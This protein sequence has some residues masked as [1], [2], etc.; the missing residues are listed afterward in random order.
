MRAA[1]PPPGAPAPSAR[2]AP[3]AN[4][5]VSGGMFQT[6]AWT[7]GWSD[8]ASGSSTIRARQPVPSGTAPQ[9]K[10]GETPSPS[11]VNRG[12]SIAPSA[13]AGLERS[14]IPK[15]PPSSGWAMQSLSAPARTLRHAWPSQWGT[16]S[17]I[18]GLLRVPDEPPCRTKAPATA[19]YKAWVEPPIGPAR[20]L[21]RSAE[22][23]SH[24]RLEHIHVDVLHRL[25]LDAI[26]GDFRLA[27]VASI[28]LGQVILV[29]DSKDIDR[30]PA[31]VRAHADLIEIPGRSI[32]I[33]DGPEPVADIG[34]G[35]DL[36][37]LVPAVEEP[38]PAARRQ[39]QY[40][41]VQRAHVAAF[42]LR[43]LRNI[44]LDL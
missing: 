31:R 39:L 3:S 33:V 29:F 37:R 12:G 43:L 2:I 15:L 40:D 24:G 17:S 14:N 4:R 36:A 8:G 25:E 35:D 22:P 5:F 30:D 16:C 44:A 18:R 1:A 27:D 11:A 7:K 13:K 28:G 20:R 21:L 9:S 19:P 38:R 23:I 32:G 10:G 41:L 6:M 34:I 26:A 42:W